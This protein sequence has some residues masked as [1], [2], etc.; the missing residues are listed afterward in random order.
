MNF[1]S[2]TFH[3]EEKTPNQFLTLILPI[4]I[5][6]LVESNA[7]IIPFKVPTTR[8]SPSR[9][10]DSAEI[11]SFT[12]TQST[13]VLCLI[14]HIQVILSNEPIARKSSLLGQ[15]EM[16]VTTEGIIKI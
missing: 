15:K 9:L 13:T 8:R 12:S 16:P 10:Y 6:L 2:V 5:S 1:I 11:T 4:Y 14:D 3:P 7:I